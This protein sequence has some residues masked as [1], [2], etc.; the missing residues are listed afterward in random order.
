MQVTESV[1]MNN[2]T[3]KFLS[4]HRIVV[5]IS[6]LPLLVIISLGLLYA[7][8]WTSYGTRLGH[9]LMYPSKEISSPVCSFIL[10][11][12]WNLNLSKNY[13]SSRGGRFAFMT[14]W[15]FEK[16]DKFSK[17]DRTAV[18]AF[19]FRENG[20]EKFFLSS[21]NGKFLQEMEASRTV[22]KIDGKRII[23][24]RYQGP[25]F[26]ESVKDG[27]YVISQNLQYKSI[28]IG[29]CSDFG[30]YGM[31]WGLSENEQNFWDVIK[32]IQWKL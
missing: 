32:S 8:N 6:A 13:A 31:F 11:N 16:A 10:P 25:K 9:A 26:M 2:K 23:F 17:K 29:F 4:K 5:V 15:L 19:L 20:N 7:W 3:Q 24:Y 21:P 22:C 14:R 12:G 1:A 28:S 18:V 27:Q 30:F